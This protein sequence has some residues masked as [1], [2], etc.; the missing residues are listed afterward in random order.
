MPAIPSIG[1]VQ[2]ARIKR[3]DGWWRAKAAPGCVPDRSQFDPS[4]FRDLL[5]NILMAELHDPFRI[6]Y[7]L[8]GGKVA[9]VA[10]RC[11]TGKYLDELG[12]AENEEPWLDRYRQAYLTRE[13]VYGSNTI[14]L[15]T[16]GEMNYEWAIWPP[17]RGSPIV[18][19][20]LGIE[21]YPKTIQ[22]T[23][24]VP[25]TSELR[26]AMAAHVD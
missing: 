16:G 26:P 5:P 1:L 6:R 7:T 22:K 20:F 19:K 13:P 17:T 11:L 10:G 4:A 2:S 14:D 21:D 8:T 23:R 15:I 25:Q 12:L 3:L 24:P 18:E 9:E